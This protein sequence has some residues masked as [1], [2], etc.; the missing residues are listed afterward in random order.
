VRTVS[1]K[2]GSRDHRRWLRTKP[3]RSP[4]I[5]WQEEDGVVVIRDL[6]RASGLRGYLIGFLKL[7]AEKTVELDEL[8]S[9]VWIRCDGRTTV[10]QIAMA[11]KERFCITQA[12]AEASL[13]A[14]LTTLARRGYISCEE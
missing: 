14:F 4:A 2:G 5:Q 3:V 11:I 7:P 13:Q 9:F 6:R 10:R 8:G 12:E 1:G